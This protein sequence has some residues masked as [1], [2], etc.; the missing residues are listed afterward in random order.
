MKERT[1]K[2]FSKS[3][4]LFDQIQVFS[5][6]SEKTDRL[7]SDD[8]I[9]L[10]LSPS[11]SITKTNQRSKFKFARVQIQV[12]SPDIGKSRKQTRL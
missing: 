6:Q 9:S 7:R 3:N 8:D 1:G 11:R 2:I 12:C 10:S 4:I 5:H